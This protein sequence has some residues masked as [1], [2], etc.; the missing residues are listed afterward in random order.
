MVPRVAQ[1][2]QVYR[3]KR[4]FLNN[5]MSYIVQRM[6]C[7]GFYCI[8]IVLAFQCGRAKTIRISYVWTRMFLENREKISAFKNF[9][10]SVDRALFWWPK[11]NTVKQPKHAIEYISW[12]KSITFFRNQTPYPRSSPLS[13]VSKLSVKPHGPYVRKGSKK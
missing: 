4:S 2:F 8:S 6:P 11:K 1:R 3:R 9:R 13:L 10:I 7:K 5:M 12:V